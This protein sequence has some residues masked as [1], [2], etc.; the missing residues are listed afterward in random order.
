MTEKTSLARVA[1]QI[2]I[3]GTMIEF[4][5]AESA[6]R[7]PNPLQS[8]EKLKIDMRASMQ[9]LSLEGAS[10]IDHDFAFQ[11]QGEMQREIESVFSRVL[12]LIQRRTP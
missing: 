1:A 5:F 4:L 11:L 8:V 6:L 9:N 10:Q 7:R 12:A 2:A 3:Y